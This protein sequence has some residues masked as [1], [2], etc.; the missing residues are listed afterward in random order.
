LSATGMMVTERPQNLKWIL[1]PFKICSWCCR[2]K[3]VR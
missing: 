3:D 1:N 2:P